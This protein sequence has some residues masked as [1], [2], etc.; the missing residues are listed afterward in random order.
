MA[1]NS[2]VLQTTQDDLN[3]LSSLLVGNSVTNLRI[4]FNKIQRRILDYQDRLTKLMANEA[5]VKFRNYNNITQAQI[6]SQYV[7]GRGTTA[8]P[9]QSFAYSTVTT[10]PDQNIAAERF[11]QL[12]QANGT[13]QI[14][15]EHSKIN[16]E[17]MMVQA[18]IRAYQAE[19]EVFQ[20]LL[21]TAQQNQPTNFINQTFG[22]V[23]SPTSDDLVKDQIAK[24]R[25]SNLTTL[26][27][28]S[29][30][31]ADLTT[32]PNTGNRAYPDEAKLPK[33]LIT[34]R[35]IFWGLVQQ[36][37]EFV[38]GENKL[39]T[40][41]PGNDANLAILQDQLS[42]SRGV[43]QNVKTT[44]DVN[45]SIKNTQMIANSTA[46]SE[47][48]SRKPDPILST[49]NSMREQTDSYPVTAVHLGPLY[50]GSFEIPTLNSCVSKWFKI[51]SA[52]HFDL[53]TCP[54]VPLP[55]PTSTDQKD[56]SA[57][58]VAKATQQAG[59][60]TYQSALALAQQFQSKAN[61]V[62]SLPPDA[63]TWVIYYNRLYGDLSNKVERIAYGTDNSPTYYAVRSFSN[64]ATNAVDMLATVFTQYLTDNGFSSQDYSLLD[65]YQYQD[66]LSFVAYGVWNIIGV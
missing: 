7:A 11:K 18:Q 62:S 19:L 51:K 65:Q 4:G 13:L 32:D 8:T 35:Q 59:L 34:Y 52:Q 27:Q 15:V 25:I 60:Q 9:Q 28:L 26:L 37:S 36:F 23:I 29:Q 61:S 66:K 22:R 53:P 48:V 56:S 5:I 24:T 10:N 3:R 41:D 30:S 44:A 21:N 38:S 54:N 39:D 46:L 14:E 1:E 16:A 55:S 43:G 42:I 45:S 12:S 50:I 6:E 64:N 49:S 17:I 33:N 47:G 63:P 57:E 31:Y 58:I 20:N 40:G 2:S